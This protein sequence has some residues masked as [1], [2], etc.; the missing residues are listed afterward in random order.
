MHVS[1]II[2]PSQEPNRI[3]LGKTTLFRLPEGTRPGSIRLGS[4]EA[5]WS[6]PAGNANSHVVGVLLREA[7]IRWTPRKRQRR[8]SDWLSDRLSGR[9]NRADVFLKLEPAIGLEPMTC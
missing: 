2:T 8:E 1:G 9:G 7:T 6:A 5:R 4:C 3:G